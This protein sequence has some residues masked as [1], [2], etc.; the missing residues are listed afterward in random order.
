MSKSNPLS[1]N[2][3]TINIEWIKNWSSLQTGYI[4][5]ESQRKNLH[6]RRGN[7]SKSIKLKN[8]QYNQIANSRTIT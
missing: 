8:G 6:N 1:G 3:L 2:G 5:R 7:K 4:E